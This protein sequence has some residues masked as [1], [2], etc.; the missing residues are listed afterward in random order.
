MGVSTLRISRGRRTPAGNRCAV[1]VAVVI[2]LT[3]KRASRAAAGEKEDAPGWVHV[4]GEED[5]RVAG[6]AS[7]ALGEPEKDTAA[8]AK[9]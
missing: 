2:P 9:T 6:V 8:P 1:A 5:D 4:K 3:E 7:K